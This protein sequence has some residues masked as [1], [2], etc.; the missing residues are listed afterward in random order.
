VCTAGGQGYDYGHGVAVDSRGDI[1]VAGA[2][3][4]EATFGD[5]VVPNENGAHLF[6][7][8]YHADGELVWVKVATGKASG[9]AHGVVVDG[10]DNIYIGGLSQARSRRSGTLAD[11]ASGRTQ[12]SVP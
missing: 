1:I 2:V 12:L 6:A 9:S 5:V 3:V 4:G 8:K 11:A 10:R 7:A